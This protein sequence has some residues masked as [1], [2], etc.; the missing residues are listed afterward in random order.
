MIQKNI[1][2][3]LIK[4][5]SNM[6]CRHENKKENTKVA[7][8]METRDA[9]FLPLVIKNFCFMLGEG[10]NFQLFINEKVEKFLAS[11]LPHFHYRLSRT[12]NNRLTPENYSFIFRQK[13]FW[14][15]IPEET[16]LIFQ[17]D[18][19]LLR[20]VPVWAEQYDMIGAPCGMICGDRCTFNGGLS[21]RKKKAMIE[22]AI[23]SMEENQKE[24]RP[25]DVFFTD[26]LWKTKDHH[27]P[28]VI[29]AFQF[30]TED[31]RSLHPIGIH[32]TD[33]YYC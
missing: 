20:P 15:Q 1:G 8:I 33:K 28:N 23:E 21:I 22:V 12:R 31:T 4:K 14:E 24:T 30:A 18:C 11:E 10:W 3:N 32:G 2:E 27:L 5:Y 6:E 26:E 16:I 17:T 25:E 9:Y 29:T 7:V 19:V 13:K